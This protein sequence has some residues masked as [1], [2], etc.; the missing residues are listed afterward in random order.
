MEKK[1]RKPKN[2][3]DFETLCKKLWGELWD[4]HE[5]K[6]NGSP[7][8]SQKG[9]DIYGIPSFELK[10][11]SKNKYYGIQCKERDENK[12][13]KLSKKD[14]DTEIQEALNFKPP[15]KM[16][17]IASTANKD[18]EIE[19]FIRLR[20]SEHIDKGLFNIEIFFWEDIE[21]LIDESYHTKNW[22]LNEI[23]HKQK[24]EFSPVFGD[25]KEKF[26]IRP[27]FDKDIFRTRVVEDYVYIPKPIEPINIFSMLG[28][29][30]GDS[31][32][33][34]KKTKNYSYCQFEI[35]MQNTG[36]QV[37]EDWHASFRLDAEF[38]K[39]YDNEEDI[40]RHH[41][42]LKT[43]YR[44]DLFIKDNQISYYPLNSEPLIQKD[45]RYFEC[46]IKPLPK[47]YVIP[48]RWE[49]LA[50]DYNASGTIDLRVEPEFIEKIEYVDIVSDEFLQ[51]DII[52]Y[53]D[54]IN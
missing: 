4:C 9:V 29:G 18:T 37:L 32:N 33:D 12:D 20:N 51:D 10:K 11:P 27:K 44:K 46:F 23:T 6:K 19:E 47:N 42:L 39:L 53:H 8:Q 31:K 36:S 21:S 50:R 48:I 15:L 41:L 14:I 54:C 34:N 49:I 3:Q 28:F 25:F 26:T 7:G 13:K 1:I 30:S 17:Y 22:W 43:H 35:V 2:W 40:N 45:N 5:I 52:K 24:Y 38:N 16:Y